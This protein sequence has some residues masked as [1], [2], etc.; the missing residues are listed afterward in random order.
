MP[1][2]DTTIGSFGRSSFGKSANED[3][4]LIFG[5]VGETCRRATL[6]AS[7]TFAAQVLKLAFAAFFGS[8]EMGPKT[9]CAFKGEFALDGLASF[10]PVCAKP[11]LTT[12]PLRAWDSFFPL[13]SD[14]KQLVCI[15]GSEYRIE[16]LLTMYSGI[17]VRNEWH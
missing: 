12:S 7:F 16:G 4:G 10:L 14:E 1:S 17:S 3:G 11:N 5:S 2:V 15:R 6:G 8:V 13:N 9:S